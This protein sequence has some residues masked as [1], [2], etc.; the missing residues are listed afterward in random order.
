[1]GIAA[2]STAAVEIIQVWATA[3][4]SFR[5]SV[6][7]L[8][9]LIRFHPEKARASRTV[10]AL[11]VLSKKGRKKGSYGNSSEATVRTTGQGELWR[12]P[13]CGKEHSR[14]L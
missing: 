14:C 1:M 7:V 2:T 13:C 6:A 10:S 5:W 3:C 11:F 8:S 4:R 9:Y 12:L